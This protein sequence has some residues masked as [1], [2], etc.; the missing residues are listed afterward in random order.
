MGQKGWP[1]PAAPA[2]HTRGQ[3]CLALRCVWT[4]LWTLM[5]G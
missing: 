5:L 4:R 3:Q 1:L 2:L